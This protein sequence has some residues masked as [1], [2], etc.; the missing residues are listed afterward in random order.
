LHDTGRRR[1]E[2]HLAELIRALHVLAPSG[3]EQRQAIAASLGFG[4]E[5]AQLQ[6]AKPTPAAFDR[7][8][9]KLTKRGRPR[10]QS[11]ATFQAPPPP[12]VPVA[13]PSVILEARLKRLDTAPPA[14][15]ADLDFLQEDVEFNVHVADA[16]PPRRADIFPAVSARASLTALLRTRR[17]GDE[18]DVAALIREVVAGRPPRRLPCRPAATLARG[19]QLLLDYGETMAPWWDD[20]EALVRQVADVAGESTVDVFDFDSDPR[21]AA[22]W[23]RDDRTPWQP[24]QGRPTLVA[25]DFSVRAGRAPHGIERRWQTLIARCKATGSPLILLTPWPRRHW[26]SWLGEYPALVHWNPRT[27]AAM[28]HRLFGFGHGTA[29]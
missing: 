25:T 5:K 4:L 13:L 19:C 22:I 29:R 23:I 27:T 8:G 17:H 1:G 20:L 21:E 28:I 24:E 6:P 7:H 18:L 10:G 15:D 26:P 3:D 14:E 9:E 12:P 16:P 11:A 2:I